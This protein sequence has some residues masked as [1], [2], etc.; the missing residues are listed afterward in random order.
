VPP[1]CSFEIDDVNKEWTYPDD[2][3]DFIHVRAM[4]GC[5]NDWVDF[6]KKVYQ[7]VLTLFLK[8][9]LLLIITG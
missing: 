3:F 4:T 5:V 7:W 2:N 1:N 6:Y 8:C 9:A